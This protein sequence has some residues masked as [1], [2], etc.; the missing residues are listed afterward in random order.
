MIKRYLPILTFLVFNL[1][2]ENLY[3]NCIADGGKTQIE[4]KEINSKIQL[5]YITLNSKDET[6]LYQ[7]I[8]TKNDFPQ[9]READREVNQIYPKI[10]VEWDASQCQVIE[11]SHYLIECSNDG[12]VIE[13][14]RTNVRINSFN[15][16]IIK[17]EN[18]RF[19][20]EKFQ[21][22]LNIQGTNFVHTSAFLFQPDACIN[23]EKKKSSK[24]N[25]NHI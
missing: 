15:T 1:H 11:K 23:S 10:R 21:I 20:Y 9:I 7:G 3:I 2:A 8:V 4:V 5:T 12:K 22:R 24:S 17:E 16:S 13:P 14:N 18:I 19:F 6:P 25:L